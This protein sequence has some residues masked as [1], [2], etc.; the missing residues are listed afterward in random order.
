MNLTPKERIINTFNGIELDR[1]AYSPRLYYWYNANKLYLG[2]RSKKYHK[3]DIPKEYLNKSQLEIYKRLEASPR[4]IFE[5]FYINLFLTR[6]KPESDVK[7]KTKKGKTKEELITEYTTPIGTLNKVE[8]NNHITEYPIKTLED[9]KVIEYA[10]KNSEF[11][12]LEDNYKKAEQ[13]LGDQGMVSEYIPRSPFMKLIV[14]LLGF[15]RTIIF[16]KRYPE[17]M[18]QFL[19]FL[20]QW[21]DRMYN[22][23]E[24]VPIRIINFGENIDAN[25][26]PPAYFKEYL[27]PYYQKRVEQLHKAGKICHIHMDGSLKDLLPFFETLPFDGLEALT[28]IPQGDVTIEELK[29]SIG[30]KVYLDGIPSILFL[31]EYSYEYLKKYT[32]KVLNAFFPNIILGVSD[33]FPP[34]GQIKKLEMISEIIESF[35]PT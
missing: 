7:I 21:D 17:Q 18:E 2:E 8:R 24:K 3:S 27:I 34:N 13:I 6:V 1:V 33:E 31:P 19:E 29:N 9:I 30:S 15:S 22:T 12:F 28:P 10:L 16:L 26:T 20:D 25:L 4:Y 35:D 14:D 32:T 5:T 23:L 11:L